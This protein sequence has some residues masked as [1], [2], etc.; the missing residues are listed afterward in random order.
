M[1]RS[2]R[3][4]DRCGTGTGRLGR[5]WQMAVVVHDPVDCRH[6]DAGA[7]P[8]YEIRHH[9]RI[10]RRGTRRYDARLG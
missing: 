6:R 3:R 4:G 8:A 2:T 1:G 9:E 5:A 10:D 7:Q